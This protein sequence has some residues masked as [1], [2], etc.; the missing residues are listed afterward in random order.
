MDKFQRADLIEALEYEGEFQTD[1]DVDACVVE[2]KRID[3]LEEEL[4]KLRTFR[5]KIR[6]AVAHTSENA[7]DEELLRRLAIQ[8]FFL[9]NAAGS[10]RR[11]GLIKTKWISSKQLDD[12]FS[13][14][15][16]DA[17]TVTEL[18]KE[19]EQSEDEYRTVA[20]DLRH[21][22]EEKAKVE[23]KLSLL[24][25]AYGRVM[26]KILYDIMPI[27]H[28]KDM[29]WTGTSDDAWAVLEGVRRRNEYLAG[30]V[31]TTL[32]LLRENLGA[33]FQVG[34]AHVVD[35][36]KQLAEKAT[37][38][39]RIQTNKEM[40]ELAMRTA[41]QTDAQL[42]DQ[43]RALTEEVNAVL[44]LLGKPP[45]GTPQ[46]QWTTGRLAGAVFDLVT[47]VRNHQVELRNFSARTFNDD[48]LKDVETLQYNTRRLPKF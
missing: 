38:Q 18:A 37:T 25:G 20:A 34:I 10:A 40:H 14:A 2:L 6:R 36:V 43:A 7:S 12:I 11:A 44:R 22:L 30:I 9:A 21:T 41:A 17:H 29:Q 46:N 42:R 45:M 28:V 16:C 19:L 47:W 13:A 31:G 32:T 39:T 15:A 35:G 24:E 26:S 3:E 5:D 4:Q 23:H 8:R 1:N 33:D 27:A 48:H